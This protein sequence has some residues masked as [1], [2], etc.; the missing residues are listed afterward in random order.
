MRTLNPQGIQTT[1]KRENTK[2]SMSKMTLNQTT[3]DPEEAEKTARNKRKAQTL[4]LKK[5]KTTA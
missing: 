1:R 2:Q 3:R 5:I 4:A